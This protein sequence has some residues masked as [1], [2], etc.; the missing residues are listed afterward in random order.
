MPEDVVREFC[1]GF[2]DEA[3]CRQWIIERLHPGGAICPECGK[4]LSDK[5]QER[6]WNNERIKCKYCGKWFTA[7]TG[8]MFQGIHMD[9]RAIIILALFLGMNQAASTVA[10]FIGGNEN[11]VRSWRSKFE[12]IRK[13][14]NR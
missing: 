13:L 1:A 10:C 6:F 11:T 8:T 4:E 9:F 5:C 3:V 12:Q 7:L 2:L 14:I